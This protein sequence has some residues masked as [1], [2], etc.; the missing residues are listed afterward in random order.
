MNFRF[1]LSPSQE[2]LGNEKPILGKFSSL[3]Q[4]GLLDNSAK[5]ARLVD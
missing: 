2:E 3:K 1:R 5:G 4:F